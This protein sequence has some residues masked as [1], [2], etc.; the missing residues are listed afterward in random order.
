MA[1]KRA[2]RLAILGC[3]GIC[4]GLLLL[5]SGCAST[6]PPTPQEFNQI[7]TAIRADEAAIAAGSPYSRPAGYL[8]DNSPVDVR[9]ENATAVV[10][11]VALGSGRIA[12]VRMKTVLDHV[13][14]KEWVVRS[15]TVYPPFWWQRA[16]ETMRTGGDLTRD[17]D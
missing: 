1:T 9:I 5:G 4:G 2:T 16:H 3:V 8:D 7:V 11:Y 13:S 15:I 12:F 14:F 17:S 10:R 6:R